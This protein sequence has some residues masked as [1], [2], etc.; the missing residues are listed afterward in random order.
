[1]EFVDALG[2]DSRET[3]GRNSLGNLAHELGALGEGQMNV[4]VGFFIVFLGL[5][6]RLASDL[7]QLEKVGVS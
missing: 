7:L 1:M 3:P 4:L 6:V 2:E 5:S